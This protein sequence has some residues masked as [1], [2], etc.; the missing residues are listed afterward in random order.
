MKYSTSLRAA[1]AA[2]SL[3]ALFTSGCGAAYQASAGTRFDVDGGREINDEDVKAAFDA[4]PQVGPES[5]V[6][7]YTFDDQK[8]ADIEE[9]LE[10]TP[11]VTSVYKIPPLL[12]TGQRHFQEANEW[13]PQQVSVKKLRVLAARAHADILIVFDH[14]WRGGGAN[15]LA[16]LNILIVPLLVTPWINNTTESYAQAFVIDVRNGYLYGDFTTE[17]K[18]GDR[19]VTIWGNT[20]SDVAEQQ[21]PKLLTNVQGKVAEKLAP[22]EPAHALSEAD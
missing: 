19:F 20:P 5:K 3:S 22:S 6:A 7:Y 21:W 10:K 1:L 12:V 18:S 8:T 4:S 13:Q 9:M 2:L 16:A 14:G 15:G 11:H 17:T